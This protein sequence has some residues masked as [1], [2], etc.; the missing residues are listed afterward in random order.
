M[1][2]PYRWA[3]AGAVL[4]LSTLG[5]Q[6][7]SAEQLA[8]AQR[9]LSEGQ[10]SL[11]SPEGMASLRDAARLFEQ[12]GTTAGQA[13]ALYWL[14]LAQQKTGAHA[15]AL[16]TIQQALSVRPQGSSS[17][18]P[19][20]FFDEQ[21]A[22]L[23]MGDLHLELGDHAAAQATFQRARELAIARKNRWSE[24]RSV[25]GLAQVH[26]RQR[27][28]EQARALWAQ[29]RAIVADESRWGLGQ[30]TK[31]WGDF[32]RAEGDLDAARK[33]YD[34]A[35]AA[36]RAALAKLAAEPGTPNH[37]MHVERSQ[38]GAA[39]ALLGAARL[40]QARSRYDAAYDA[41]RQGL[42]LMATMPTQPEKGSDGLAWSEGP[43]QNRE[44][45]DQ[46]ESAKAE[47]QR[48]L[49]KQPLAPEIRSAI[50]VNGGKVIVARSLVERFRQ[51]PDLLV[52][53]TRL[54]PELKNDRIIGVRIFGVHEDT[55]S[56]ALGFR[57]GDRVLKI[58]GQPAVGLD[59]W[60]DVHAIIVGASS[61]RVELERQNQPL[62][63]VF[64]SE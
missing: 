35:I 62:E 9:K 28:A 24:W 57:N 22:L 56:G 33:L 41:C 51:D 10:A 61:I 60:Q 36:H 46:L 42:A 44:V 13:E 7:P 55:L 11:R 37:L 32:E 58:N 49:A 47:V 40:E 21:E 53:A 16:A 64:V 4:L 23:M 27:Q 48:E 38:L 30:L 3:A 20:R 17:T 6:R 39:E 52:R 1:A 54:V 63:L 5:C 31:R 12:A 2:F 19:L 8:V 59:R 18:D 34:D 14:A 43:R 25:E 50:R 29:A 26:A 15:E 45:I